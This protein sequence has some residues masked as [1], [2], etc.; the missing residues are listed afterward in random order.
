MRYITLEMT[1]DVNGDDETE[2]L[3]HLVSNLEVDQSR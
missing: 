2:N 1:N 3:S